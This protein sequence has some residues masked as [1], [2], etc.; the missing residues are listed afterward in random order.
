MKWRNALAAL[1]G[2]W[3]IISPWVFDY[4]NNT[5]AL[6]TSVVIGAVQLIVSAWAMAKSNSSGWNV[7][8]TW[9]SLL[10]GIWFVVQAFVYSFDNAT[11]WVTFILGAVTVILNLWTMAAK[12]EG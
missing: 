1:I 7:W 8:Q 11:I 10:T 9:I 5:A 12:V 2:I 6:W 4:A 3:F